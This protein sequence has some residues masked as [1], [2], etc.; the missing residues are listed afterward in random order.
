MNTNESL[1]SLRSVWL[2]RA[3][4]QLAK[5]ASL[6]E[7]FR[8]QLEKFFDALEQA[9]DTGEPVWLDSILN[10][11]SSSLTQTD[12]E[13]Q[14]SSLTT[15]IKE[16][17]LL[18]I[19]LCHESLE[20]SEAVNVL[21]AIVP[22][23]AYAFEQ[24]S[25]Y[26]IEARVLYLTH[27]LAEVQSYMQSLDRAKSDFVAVAAHELRT[28]LTLVEGYAAMLQ[29]TLLTP[30]NRLQML[31]G[32]QN[33]ANRLRIIIDDMIDVS[34]IDNNLL[35]LNFQP[36]WLN[37]IFN[38]LHLELTPTL[39]ERN[40]ELTIQSFPGSTELIYADSERIYQLFRNLLLNSIKFT[41]DSGQ[42]TITGRKLPGFIEIIITD[43]G[44]GIS[45]EGLN[46][47]FTKFSRLDNSLQH[48]SGKT[49]FKGGGP[50]LGLHI[51]RGIIEAH[52]GAIWAESP[53]RDEQT[54]PGSTFHILL[55]LRTQPPDGKAAALFSQFHQSSLTQ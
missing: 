45:P 51:A 13:I 29:D 37:R 44:I 17:F 43:T 55:P 15:F 21:T 39:K 2:N 26:E 22:P 52:E 4:V 25:H 6:R 12:L 10:I 8:E 47:L 41:P 38:G 54:C 42:I 31:N 19:Q 3:V 9:V 53:G 23:F 50:G 11:W 28:P 40:Q 16:L 33:G 35:K 1:R 30:E 48:S 14:Q 18:T 27:R 24:V 34:L 32:I 5:G 7:D 46:M 49:K 20:P 36:T